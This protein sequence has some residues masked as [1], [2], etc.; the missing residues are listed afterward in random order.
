[1]LTIMLIIVIIL[2]LGSDGSFGY[3]R[4]GGTGVG[5]VL[6]LVVIVLFP[7]WPFGDIHFHRL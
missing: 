4:Y 7:L 1:M 5:R 3:N 2:L 6:G